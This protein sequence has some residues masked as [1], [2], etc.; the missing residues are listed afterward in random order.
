MYESS[1]LRGVGGVAKAQDERFLA[2]SICLRAWL[3]ACGAGFGRKCPASAFFA[4][5]L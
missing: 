5:G 1:V 3:H 4:A 2:R